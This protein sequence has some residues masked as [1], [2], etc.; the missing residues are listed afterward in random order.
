MKLLQGITFVAY[1]SLALCVGVVVYRVHQQIEKVERW[2]EA[3]D[4][5]LANHATIIHKQADVVHRLIDR[6]KPGES[7]TPSSLPK[8][9]DELFDRGKPTVVLY[10]IEGCGPCEQWWRDQAPQWIAN[11]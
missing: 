6:L 3:I 1:L 11:G 2:V 10:S 5:T 8:Q 9:E 7:P 4:A